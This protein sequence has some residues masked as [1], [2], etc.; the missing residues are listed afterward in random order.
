MTNGTKQSQGLNQM[1]MKEI[2]RRKFKALVDEQEDRISDESEK[3]YDSDDSD[4]KKALKYH[5]MD[6]V[7]DRE[8]TDEANRI[9]R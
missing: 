9:E 8:F 4:L 6:L 3:D 2:L 7:L 1:R 5:K